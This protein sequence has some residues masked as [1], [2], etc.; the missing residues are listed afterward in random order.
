M[1][2][3]ILKYFMYQTITKRCL[4]SSEDY[5]LSLT[6]EC[7]E[8][9]VV[10]KTALEHILGENRI[11][12]IYHSD[13]DVQHCRHEYVRLLTENSIYISMTKTSDPYQNAIK[14]G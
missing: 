1:A 9:V 2:C 11:G 12:L 7:N 10:L 4:F 5:R 8:A 6:L 13:R 3:D 14:E